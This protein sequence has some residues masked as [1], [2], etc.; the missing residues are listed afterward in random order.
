MD[1]VGFRDIKL[2]VLR[3]IRNSQWVPGDLLPSEITLA[4]EFNCARATV[5]RALREL[6]EEGVVDRRRK[7]GTRVKTSPVQQ[8]KFEIPLIRAEVEAT[9]ASYRFAMVT[10]EVV[11]APDWLRAR[12]AVPARTRM[13]HLVTMHYANNA[14]FLYED[15]WIN[16]GAVPNAEHAD[17]QQANPNEWLFHQLPFTGA[18]VRYSATSADTTLAMFLQ[19]PVGVPVFT[20]DRTTWLGDTPITNARLY[21]SPGYQLVARY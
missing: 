9:G 13:R 5:N 16:L 14:P 17:F 2:E 18:E 8:V 12:L 21:F 11:A 20:S 7:S 4:S 6:S 1:R 19:T 15:R 3:R 10:S